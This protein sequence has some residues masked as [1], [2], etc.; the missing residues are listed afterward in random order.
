M[1][2]LTVIH[3]SPLHQV[4]KTGIITDDREMVYCPE[5]WS[6]NV[7]DVNVTW[8]W[9]LKIFKQKSLQPPCVTIVCPMKCRRIEVPDGQVVR[10]GISVM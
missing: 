10:A 7:R 1:S 8:L 5:C 3:A 9:A 2:A 4:G 6:F